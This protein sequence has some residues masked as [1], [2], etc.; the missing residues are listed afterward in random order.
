MQ[1]VFGVLVGLSLGAILCWRDDHYNGKIGWFWVGIFIISFL[2]I[3][4]TQGSK[5]Y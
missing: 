5:H 2:G 1:T 4:F 3:I